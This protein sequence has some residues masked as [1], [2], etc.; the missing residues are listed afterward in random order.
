M[1]VA[2][3]QWHH[4]IAPVF[5]T[6]SSLLLYQKEKGV[7][8]VVGEIN[9]GDQSSDEKLKSIVDMGA[10]TLICG[11]IPYRYEMQLKQA[12]IVVI[13]FIAGELSTIISAF[14]ENRLHESIYQMPG[15]KN[16]TQRGL[17]CRFV[18]E[19]APTTESFHK[20]ETAY[21]KGKRDENSN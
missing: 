13:P 18:A 16:R 17:H 20:R 10:K 8:V 7:F 3:P 4:R 6:I 5:D 15:C 2:I 12:D 21:N 19:N 14:D 11:A 1:K 9:I